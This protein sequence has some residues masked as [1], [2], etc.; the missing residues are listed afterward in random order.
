YQPMAL[1]ALV[2]IYFVAYV[3]LRTLLW[4]ENDRFT[5]LRLRVGLSWALT[6]FDPEAEEYDILPVRVYFLLLAV[7]ASG[8][9]LR[10][11]ARWVVG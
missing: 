9:L 5:P 6:G 2:A 1:A 8:L 7:L 3:F 11:V 10:P 4:M